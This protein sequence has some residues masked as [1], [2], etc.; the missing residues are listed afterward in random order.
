[1]VERAHKGKLGPCYRM[2]S[3]VLTAKADLWRQRNS[4]HLRHLFVSKEK[5][6]RCPERQPHDR[7]EVP[8]FLSGIKCRIQPSC[9]D[10][11]P[12]LCST[13]MAWTSIPQIPNPILIPNCRALS[14]MVARV[15]SCICE[16][17]FWDD[18]SL[19]A[20]RTIVEPATALLRANIQ[21]LRTVE[22]TKPWAR[23]RLLA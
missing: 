8:V 3:A 22:Y 6:M 21:P 20:S 12:T 2:V 13:L 15:N 14:H 4:S 10:R 9:S 18:R 16:P 17:T 19:R 11:S 5:G 7:L 23:V 1:M